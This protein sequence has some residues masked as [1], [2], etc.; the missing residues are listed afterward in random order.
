MISDMELATLQRKGRLRD[1]VIRV[2][3]FPYDFGLREA[4]ADVSDS[5]QDK[6][7]EAA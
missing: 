7:R 2:D 6:R 3:D 5:D 1:L 4:L